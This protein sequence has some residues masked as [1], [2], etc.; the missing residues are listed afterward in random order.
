[1]GTQ[2]HGL[3]YTDLGWDETRRRAGQIDAFAS[4]TR[5]TSVTVAMMCFSREK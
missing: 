5:I 4:D 2:F 3:V 1:M